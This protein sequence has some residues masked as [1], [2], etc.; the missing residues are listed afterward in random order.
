M[1]H[2][3]ESLS[4][5]CLPALPLSLFLA[6][7]LSSIHPLPL[8]FSFYNSNPV[9]PVPDCWRQPLSPGK[10]RERGKKKAK[11]EKKLFEGQS[12][13]SHTHTHTNSLS[14]NTHSL[15]ART[16]TR[17]HTHR[18]KSRMKFFLF[19]FFLKK[20]LWVDF[21]GPNIFPL[22]TPFFFPFFLFCFNLSLSLYSPPLLP[23]F[24]L[25]TA[26]TGQCN[27]IPLCDIF[28]ASFID[29]LK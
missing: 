13:Q 10:K 25:P 16:L 17:T 18:S 14:L 27:K 19:P 26:L 15:C 7:S 23:L 8:P 4:F 24:D 11:E 28:L 9:S 21:S 6:R 12:R 22:F 1:T 2:T 5:P 3:N 29:L 20:Q